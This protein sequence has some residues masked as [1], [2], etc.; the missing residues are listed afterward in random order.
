MIKN[1]SSLCIGDLRRDKINYE[2]KT[3]IGGKNNNKFNFV[4]IRLNHSC[5][6]ILT[7]YY[8]NKNNIENFGEL[9]IFKLKKED[10]KN[11]VLK[12]GGYAH[13]TIKKLGPITNETLNSNI[14]KEYQIRPIY[15]SPC[16]NDLL[17][18]RVCEFNV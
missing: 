6:Y 3:S 8:I 12:Y 18:F 7:A 14:H 1:K 9:F 11:I 2:I 13:G 4:Q 10:M 16:W 15:G 5:D 17:Q